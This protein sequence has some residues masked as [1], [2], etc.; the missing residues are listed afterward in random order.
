MHSTLPASPTSQPRCSDP[1]V[2]MLFTGPTWVLSVVAVGLPGGSEP[3]RI[4]QMEPSRTTILKTCVTSS[5]PK[6]SS[7][8]VEPP[9]PPNL[10]EYHKWSLPQ[11]RSST[12]SSLPSPEGRSFELRTPSYPRLDIRDE[13][14]VVAAALK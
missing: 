1:G 14:A 7:S 6:L 10:V 12:H 11:P 13:S 4:Q 5:L 3:C 9:E 8:A 2:F